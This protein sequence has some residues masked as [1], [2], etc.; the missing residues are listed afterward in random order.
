MEYNAIDTSNASE[1]ATGTCSVSGSQPE[2]NTAQF[3]ASLLMLP[4]WLIEVPLDLGT[5]WYV[6]ARPE[7][8]RC[9]VHAAQGRTVC[10]LKNGRVNETFSSGLPGG[11]SG[12]KSGYCILDCIYHAINKTYY[13][14]GMYLQHFKREEK[15]LNTALLMK[16]IL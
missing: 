15:T 13:V 10:R 7:G 8:Q 12:D 14:L 2:Q 11:G 1:D 3:W 9:I 5:A 6:A 16:Y 4:E